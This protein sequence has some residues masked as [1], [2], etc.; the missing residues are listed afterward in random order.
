MR[1]LPILLLAAGSAGCGGGATVGDSSGSPAPTGPDTTA[2]T[3]AIASYIATDTEAVHA[4]FESAN[5]DRAF[6]VARAGQTCGSVDG[7]GFEAMA[8]SYTDQ[9]LTDIDAKVRAEVAVGPINKNDV[10]QL[11][12]SARSSESAYYQDAA[13]VCATLP[14]ATSRIAAYI[15]SAY[16]AEVALLQAVGA[17]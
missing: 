16:A 2:A 15:D 10:T 14:N 6:A 11:I 8:E 5:R 7:D 3:L 12:D 9:L 1:L 4:L 17:L 13:P